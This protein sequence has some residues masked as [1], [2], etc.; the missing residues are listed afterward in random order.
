[1]STQDGARV[2]VLTAL[3]V[4][5]RAVRAHVQDR[6]RR[7]HPRGTQFEVGVL[8][9]VDGRI[10]IA[11][12]GKGNI[13]A[14]LGVDH[15]V[16]LFRPSAILFVGIAGALHDDL[17]IGDVV[18]AVKVYAY[19][20]GMETDA[21]LLARPDAHDADHEL[22]QLAQMAAH[23]HYELPDAP[24]VHFRAVAAGDVV[25]N[26]RTRPLA[27][28][29]VSHYNDAG[30]IEMESAGMARACHVC[31]VPALVVRGISDRADGEKETVDADGW[32][33]LA[34]RNAADFA[35]A[36]IRDYLSQPHEVPAAQPEQ[37]STVQNIIGVGAPAFGAMHGDVH[38]HAPED[39]LALE[40]RTLSRPPPVPWRKQE[41]HTIEHTALELHLIPVGDVAR[42]EV[43][44]LP[45]LADTLAGL[46]PPEMSAKSST[47]EQAARAVVT[48]HEFGPRGLLV[49]R[50]GVRSAWEP[51]PSDRLGAI[52][53]DDWVTGR[54]AIA[55]RILLDLD[56]P[57]AARYAPAV[58]V[59]KAW[60]V[61]VDSIGNLPRTHAGGFGR[62]NIAQVPAE[63]SLPATHLERLTGEVAAELTARL[64]A[65][66]RR[67]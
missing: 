16:E 31:R 51:L 41:N 60:M 11:Q 61:T 43:R 23:D 66:F 49:S 2:V 20:G 34:A 45:G 35:V 52:F 17:R 22:L 46:L 15:A 19:Q 39:P 13:D 29:L 7:S 58:A 32:Q 54:L 53:D 42:I 25:L 12:L 5:Y 27:K 33:P 3:P 30:A 56:L 14:A 18:V 57:R 28:Q 9:G 38:I 47:D 1:M 63:E 6:V 36:V 21:G 44:R 10:A 26:S 67:R 55:L 8:P 40:W 4:E 64:A 59:S 62:T 50:D 37:S 24:P 65:I 48:G